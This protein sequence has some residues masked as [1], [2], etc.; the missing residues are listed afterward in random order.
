MRT[1]EAAARLFAHALNPLAHTEEGLDGAI[2]IATRC[3]CFALHT[4]DLPATCTLVIRTLQELGHGAQ[5]RGA[6]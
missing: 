1:A 2:A 5:H 4:A 3:C 6:S